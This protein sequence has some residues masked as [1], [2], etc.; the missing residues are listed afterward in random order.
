M[1]ESASRH[2]FLSVIIALI[3]GGSGC[4]PA[5]SQP[6]IASFKVHVRNVKVNLLSF[7]GEKTTLLDSA[8]SSDQGE[9]FFAFGAR[10]EPG[11]YRISLGRQQFL[12]FIYNREN[13]SIEMDMSGGGGIPRALDS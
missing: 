5:R 13:I 4:I 11:I 8:V 9:V 12:D 1:Q 6:F 2:T 7:Y 10:R 3:L